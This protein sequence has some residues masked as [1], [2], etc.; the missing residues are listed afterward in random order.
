[1]GIVYHTNKQTGITYAYENK[2]H[3]DKKK[4]QSRSIRKLIGKVDPATGNIVPTRAYN[5]QGLPVGERSP[6]PGPVPITKMQR[7][8]YGASYLFDEI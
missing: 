3:W 1:M 6:I 4:Q 5:K 8:F 2:A 7:S